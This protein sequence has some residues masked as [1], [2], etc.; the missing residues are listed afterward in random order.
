MH[1]KDMDKLRKYLP[2]ILVLLTVILSI[3][4]IYYLI[5][6]N[7]N[8]DSEVLTELNATKSEITKG[9]NDP[10]I[11]VDIFSDFRCPACRYANMTIEPALYEKYKDQVQFR[12]RHF[13]LPSHGQLAVDASEA[14]E[15]VF[16]LSNSDTFWKY[17]NKL[18]V[19]QGTDM[20]EVTFTL[21]NFGLWAEEFG[22]NK[23]EFLNSMNSAKYRQNVQKDID[24]GNKLGVSWTPSWFVNGKLVKSSSQDLEGISKVIDEALKNL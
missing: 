4:G 12:F 6:R 18:F 14:A 3:L 13:P 20:G 16:R 1:K 24:L 5:S 21:D 22:V 9:T 8:K 15:T 10:K 7:G 23:E 17:A 11:I 19:E 2:Q